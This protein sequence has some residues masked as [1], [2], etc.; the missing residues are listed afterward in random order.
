MISTLTRILLIGSAFIGFLYVVTQ[1]R[2]SNF[3]IRDSIFW[4]FFSIVLVIIAIFPNI[5]ISLSRVFGIESPTN[6]IFIVII[7]VMIVRIYR[8]S[9]AVSSLN[10]KIKELTQTLAIQ[11]Y[12]TSSKSNSK[13]KR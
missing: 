12:E 8:L 6:F 1:I 9:V 5:P 7:A 13:K 11:D 2:N 3:T 4:V 10:T